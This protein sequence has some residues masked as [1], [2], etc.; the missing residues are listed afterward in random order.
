MAALAPFASPGDVQAVVDALVARGEVTL[1]DGTL[2]LTE[3]GARARAELAA[4]VGQVRGRV[5]SALSADEY[6]ALIALLTRLVEAVRDGA[7]P[8]R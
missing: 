2:R 5:A 8:Q 7:P 3:G 6:E 4:A 1:A